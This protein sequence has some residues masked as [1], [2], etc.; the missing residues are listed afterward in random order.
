MWNVVPDIYNV[1]TSPHIQACVCNWTYLRCYW[2]YLDISMHDILQT[3]SQIQRTSSSLHYVICGPGHMQCSYISAY[4]GFN[5]QLNVSALI[6]EIC[7]QFNATYTAIIVPNTAHTLYITL[8]KLWSRTYTMYLQL[9]IFRLPYAT[10]RICPAV[11]GIS[12]I[13]NYLHCNH[14]AKY[15]AHPLYYAMWIVVTD[16]YNVLTAPHIQ[17]TIFSWTY[18]RRYWRYINN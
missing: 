14:C 11:G 5:I 10:E 3:G 12:T 15:S 18:F 4:S 16:I 8:C 13:Q 17:D 6:L 9:H 1:V 7:T 2:R